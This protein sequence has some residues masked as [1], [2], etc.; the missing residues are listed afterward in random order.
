MSGHVPC[1]MHHG[2]DTFVELE[3]VPLVALHSR[4]ILGVHERAHVPRHVVAP[5]NGL[6]PV[7]AARVH[8]HEVAWSLQ[9]AIY[10]Y[11]VRAQ[12]GHVGPPRA[13][14]VAHAMLPLTQLLHTRPILFGHAEPLAVARTDVYIERAK[15]GILLVPGS[16]APG[17]L[18]IHLHRVAAEDL[19]ATVSEH[20]AGRDEAHEG[21]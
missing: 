14:L 7:H 3:L 21:R 20:V 2:Y 16:A 12:L 5:A 1:Q 15:V 4:P 11:T 18:K 19:V 13:I 9:K 6:H 8:P 17:Y 10:G